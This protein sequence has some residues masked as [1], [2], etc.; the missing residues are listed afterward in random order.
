MLASTPLDSIHAASHHISLMYHH[1][2]HEFPRLSGRARQKE[3][4]QV[5]TR[6]LKELHECHRE[7]EECTMQLTSAL[8]H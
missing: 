3:L 7:W 1:I 5:K 2:E 6:L 8:G 4:V